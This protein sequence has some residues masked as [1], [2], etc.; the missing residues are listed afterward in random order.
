MFDKIEIKKEI[1]QNCLDIYHAINLLKEYNYIDST[2]ALKYEHNLLFDITGRFALL[3]K[4]ENEDA[5][6]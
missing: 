3:L 1:A 6:S 4:K 5:S 2:T